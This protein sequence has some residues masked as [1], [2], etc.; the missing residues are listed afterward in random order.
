MRQWRRHDA[1]VKWTRLVA[2]GNADEEK[3]HCEFRVQ[4][5][6]NR[7]NNNCYS[8][9]INYPIARNKFACG[10]RRMSKIEWRILFSTKSSHSIAETFDFFLFFFSITWNRLRD[11]I[12]DVNACWL[13][14]DHSVATNY[15]NARLLAL[16]IVNANTAMDFW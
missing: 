8:T 3:Y 7:S 12:N 5:A 16:L 14:C 15:H 6:L 10:C 1:S 13:V 4:I 9:V 11:A 2:A